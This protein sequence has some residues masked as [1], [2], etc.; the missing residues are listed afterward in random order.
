MK[1]LIT[2]K[3]YPY[4]GGSATNAYKLTKYLRKKNIKTGCLFFNNDNVDVDP[5]KIFGIFKLEHDSKK[6][7]IKKNDSNKNILS[8]IN[9]FFNGDPTIILAFNYY[10]P[11]IS[12]NTFKNSIIVYMAVGCAALTMGN[13]SCINNNI[14]A[15]KFLK[16]DNYKHYITD[17]FFN[18]ER[19]TIDKSDHILIDHGQLLSDILIKLYPKYKNKLNNYIDYGYLVVKNDLN[20]IKNNIKKYDIICI[21]SNWS[22]SVKNKKLCFDILSH[23]KNNNKIIIGKN[24]EEF[25]SINNIEVIDFCEYNKVLNYLSESKILIV[26]SFFESGPNTVLEAINNNCQVITTKNI[27]YNHLLYNYNLCK[28]VYDISGWVNKI[29]YIINNFNILNIPKVLDQDKLFQKYLNKLNL[30]ITPPKN[31]LLYNV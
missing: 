10:V 21:S 12:K 1:I 31:K 13:K 18:L 22:R 7:H 19:E 2:A 27:G 26:T 11:I 5:D 17:K 29:N 9:D 8:K 16:M 4:W 6:R 28:D 15:S 24:T 25:N 23:F 20:K 3:Q 14:S 30:N